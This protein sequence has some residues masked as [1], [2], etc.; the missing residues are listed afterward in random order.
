MKVKWTFISEKEVTFTATIS[1]EKIDQQLK[2][3]ILNH[4]KDCSPFL[5]IQEEGVT[6][7]ANLNQMLLFRREEVNEVDV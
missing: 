1:D 7:G 4:N 6:T 2:E 5:V 3:R